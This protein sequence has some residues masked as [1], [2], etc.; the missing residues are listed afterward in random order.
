MR[1]NLHV[2]P[3]TPPMSGEEFKAHAGPCSIALDGY[4][5]EGPWYS[6]RCGDEGPY[7][8]FNHHEDVDRSS[9]RATCGQVLLAIRS[10]LFQAFRMDA[11][12]TAHVYVND[13]DEDVC[14]SWFLLNNA[15]IAQSSTNP[16]LNR[17]ADIVDKLDTTAGAYPLPP[18]SPLQGELAWIFNPY[19]RFR[20]AGGLTRRD[21]EEFRGVITDVENRILRYV[22]GQGK[23]IPVDTRYERIGG[24]QG[25]VLVK[26]VGAQSRTGMFGDGIQAFLSV[27]DQIGDRFDYVV[28]RQSE[29]VPF[30]VP[31][32]L[33]TLNHVEGTSGADRWG[34]GNTIGGSPRISGSR[35]PPDKVSAVI[36]DV[37]AAA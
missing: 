33:D 20:L 2:E 16:M 30:P 1:V 7:R 9:T 13:C 11:E 23:T 22:V 34:G 5:C 15:H 18:D 35:L 12:P 19:R 24:G 25:W 36:E 28:G 8:N 21:A 14:L 32:I 6:E 4:V 26:E 29:Y 37:L 27:R 3:L 31:K 10:G 17:L